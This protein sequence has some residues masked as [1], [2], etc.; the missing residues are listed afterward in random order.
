MNDEIIYQLTREEAIQF[1]ESEAWKCWADRERA[2]FQLLQDKICM[3]MKVFFKSLEA[4][5]GRLVLTHELAYPRLL[6][7]EL[8]GERE[9]PTLHELVSRLPRHL[10]VRIRVLDAYNDN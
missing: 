2:V 3:P 9:Q 6:L 5:L 8:K 7:E 4:A 10:S 1:S